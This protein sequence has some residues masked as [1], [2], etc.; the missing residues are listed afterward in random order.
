M[1][2]GNVKQKDL[3]PDQLKLCG[4]F[5]DEVID[6]CNKYTKLANP[7]MKFFGKERNPWEEST[8][9]G[10]GR[11]WSMIWK[12]PKWDDLDEIIIAPT[13]APAEE[14]ASISE[15][16]FDEIREEYEDE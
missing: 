12:E 5:C 11:R 1:T 4:A 9:L 16:D 13:D 8:E 2:Y 10:H 15:Q 14:G 3:N 6:V 7:T